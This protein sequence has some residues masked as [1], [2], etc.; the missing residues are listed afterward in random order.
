MIEAFPTCTVA[1]GV[2][3]GG[4]TVVQ[5][6]RLQEEAENQGNNSPLLDDDLLQYYHF[7]AD[8]GDQ[9]A[10]VKHLIFHFIS[11]LVFL[12]FFFVLIPFFFFFFVLPMVF[13][14]LSI[15]LSQTTIVQKFVQYIHSIKRLM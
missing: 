14:H 3:F 8:K 12:T 10:Q 1:D 15:C 4:G 11:C 6:V 2:T 5:R 9:Q 13:Y 7:L